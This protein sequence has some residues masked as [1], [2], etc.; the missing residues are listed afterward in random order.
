[1]GK[2]IDSPISKE[3]LSA[4]YIDKKM[5]AIEIAN[6]KGVKYQQIYYLLK[7][8]GIPRRS[9]QA[10]N[11]KSDINQNYFSVI[12]SPEKAYWLG[13]LYAD[14]YVTARH[15]VGLA[16]SIIDI[17]HV[18]KFKEAISATHKIHVYES[19]GYGTTPYAKII[20][21]CPKMVDDL[22]RLGCVQNKTLILKFPTSS[23]VPPKFIRDFIRG[24][25][26]GDGSITKSGKYHPVRLSFCGTKEFLIGLMECLNGMISPDSFHVVLD[27]RHKDDKNTYQIAIN[28]TRRVQKILHEL[29]D[30]ASVYLDRKY[31]LYQKAVNVLK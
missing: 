11:T 27:K 31:K 13:F 23:Q 6:H 8:Y 30:D 1:M 15:Q 24:Y 26:D 28:G 10:M 17:E 21:S 20:I 4:I 3:E 9:F 7:K 25:L 18:K 5:S 2:K 29:Y 22:E 14:G 16:L 12:D 19:S